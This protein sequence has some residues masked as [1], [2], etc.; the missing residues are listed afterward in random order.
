MG[1]C[2]S[3][4]TGAA[5]TPTGHTHQPDQNTSAAPRQGTRSRRGS[6][7]HIELEPRVGA[8]TQSGPSRRTPPPADPRMM[9]VGDD[10]Y[11]TIA[12]AGTHGLAHRN[13]RLDDARRARIE[14]RVIDGLLHQPRADGR[15]VPMTTEEDTM[16][17]MA[18]DGRIYAATAAIVDNHTGFMAGG[19]VAAAGEL[20]VR[21][22]RL[23]HIDNYSGHY[24]PSLECHAQVLQRLGSQ[25][26]QLPQS[27]QNPGAPAWLA[28]SGPTMVRG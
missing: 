20:T 7:T 15:F 10:R 13:Y 14:V 27:E 1:S 22:G 17:V 2:I 9:R 25:Q 21:D 26:V 18:G 16:F 6:A 28:S 24:A 12:P 23:I 11:Y 5:S 3:S 8:S 4:P 19:R